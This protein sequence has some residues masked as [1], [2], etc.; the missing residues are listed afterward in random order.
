MLPPDADFDEHGEIVT[1]SGTN[2]GE[3]QGVGEEILQVLSEQSTEFTPT[4]SVADRATD[5]D[6][7]DVVTGVS[8]D[9]TVA[10]IVSSDQLVGAHLPSHLV[11]SVD[12]TVVQPS[13]DHAAVVELDAPTRLVTVS[14][15]SKMGSQQ[16]QQ[17]IFT[18]QSGQPLDAET[19]QILL[20]G[21]IDDQTLGDGQ[22]QIVLTQNPDGSLQQVVLSQPQN[23][24]QGAEKISEVKLQSEPPAE[25][26]EAQG[27]YIHTPQGQLQRILVAKPPEIDM[28]TAAGKV[29]TEPGSAVQQPD[30]AGSKNMVIKSVPQPAPPPA[31]SAEEA[32]P[33]EPAA[34]VSDRSSVTNT[35]VLGSSQNP[36]RI[37][38]Q[39]NQYTSLQQL[40]PEQLSQIMQVVQQQQVARKASSGDGTS[41]LFNPVTQTRIVYRVIY[42]S[43]LHSQ[44]NGQ[45]G[46]TGKKTRIQ[47]QM[48]T[49]LV[50]LQAQ[51]ARRPYRKRKLQDDEDKLDLPELSK[52]ER[53]ERKKHRPRTRSGRVSK[54]PKHMVQDY[55]QIHLVDWDEDYDDSDGGYS[56]FKNSDEEGEK[57]KDSAYAPYLMLGKK[58]NCW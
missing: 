46:T 9:A 1:I 41:V 19:Q 37:V 51:P 17:I 4:D 11:D 30:N 12:H 35:P 16:Q 32:L 23:E 33:A 47:I 8:D 21:G 6:N 25:E 18:D 55:K 52:K 31:P 45:D 58:Q 40:T 57:K 53:E 14:A 3:G 54:P 42:P 20:G 29:E 44:Q 34:S 13:S 36:I 27:V 22:H 24:Q 7:V 5:A 38:Q 10:T 15:D 39:G 56:D 50:S 48:P 28:E 26:N 2:V 43:E 49:S